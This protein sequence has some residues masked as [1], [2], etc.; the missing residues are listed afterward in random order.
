MRT[1]IVSF[2]LSLSLIGHASSIELSDGSFLA[3]Y[4]FEQVLTKANRDPEVIAR[5]D[6]ESKE[7]WKKLCSKLGTGDHVPILAYGSLMNPASLKKTITS[8]VKDPS[9]VW[10]CDYVRVFNYSIETIGSLNRVTELDGPL[11]RAVLNLAYAPGSCCTALVLCLNEED[12][13]SCRRREG[14][15]DLVP[16]KVRPYLIQDSCVSFPEVA[17]AWI[18]RR[19][20]GCSR[21]VLPI[22]GYYSMIWDAVSSEATVTAFGEKFPQDYL[23]T[24]FLF[25]GRSVR[26]IH[27]EYKKA[28]FLY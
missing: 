17:Y 15:Y 19:E 1:K 12:F 6:E 20:E 4:T 16:V 11:N 2:F 21:P 18:V 23:D 5:V 26:V 3:A 14:V 8:L 7:I 10:I 24:T 28:P 27:D 22:K 13:L 9:P 25:D